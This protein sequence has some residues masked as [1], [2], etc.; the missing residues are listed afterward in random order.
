MTECTTVGGSDPSDVI[1]SLFDIHFD[2]GRFVAVEEIKGGYC[3][4]SYKV[5]VAQGE[6][7]ARLF[8][9]GYN[10]QTS[11]GEIRFE[12][13]LLGHLSAHGFDLIASPLPA[14]NGDTYVPLLTSVPDGTRPTLWS[15]FD[16][17]EG[18]DKY[19]WTRINLSDPEFDSAAETLAALHSAGFGFTPAADEV[20][21]QIP[22]I[23]KSVPMFAEAF[24]R[25][26]QTEGS[27]RCDLLLRKR[28]PSI[29]KVIDAFSAAAEGF[30]GMPRVPIHGDYHP[31][32]LKYR[33]G[34]AVAVFD[35][36][37]SK[38]DYRLLEVAMALVY[39]C[40]QWEGP[41]AGCF[42]RE[43]LH[44]FLSIYDTTCRQKGRL[45]PLTPRERSNF[46][47]MLAAAN[48][49]ILNWGVTDFYRLENP[50]DE[51]YLYYISHNLDL[52]TWIDA[53]PAETEAALPV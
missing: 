34:R 53:H 29:L 48:L 4:K 42:D 26:V 23:V 45:T 22:P 1:P 32:N 8:L 27:R 41:K 43:R 31:G 5:T 18:E 10:P 40:G 30:Q 13:A 37:W 24:T 14:R 21:I 50:N 19:S 2:L 7:E 16:F 51:E 38:I 49:F 12:H 33:N 44:R 11:E 25:Y 52:M 17:L 20:R 28:L 36:D 9:R 6:N 3:N 15:V 35:F 47:V 39:F 46:P